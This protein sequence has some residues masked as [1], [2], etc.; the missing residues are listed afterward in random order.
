MQDNC[1]FLVNIHVT[2]AIPL[3]Y[4]WA[5]DRKASPVPD[6]AS[7]RPAWDGDVNHG[8]ISFLYQVL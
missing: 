6:E 3:Y 7:F 4:P 1:S 5:M 8:Y 2:K